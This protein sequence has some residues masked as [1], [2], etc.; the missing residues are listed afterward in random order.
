VKKSPVITTSLAAA[1]LPGQ[2]LYAIVRRSSTPHVK[3]AELDNSITGKKMN[4][5]GVEILSPPPSRPILWFNQKAV[6]QSA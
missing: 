6:R 3:V 1:F 2:P 4:E 5:E